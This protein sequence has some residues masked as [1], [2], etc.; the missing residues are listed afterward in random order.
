MSA[1]SCSSVRPSTAVL[2]LLHEVCAWLPPLLLLL[3]LLLLPTLLLLLLPTLLL[4]LPPLLPVPPTPASP[5]PPSSRFAIMAILRARRTEIASSAPSMK[6]SSSVRIRAST[7]LLLSSCCRRL[8]VGKVAETG[9]IAS[10]PG[11]TA[12]MV[13]A[14]SSAS[15]C[16]RCTP[17]FALRLRAACAK[18]SRTMIYF[19]TLDARFGLAPDGYCIFNENMQRNLVGFSRPTSRFSPTSRVALPMTSTTARALTVAR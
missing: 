13:V 19:W 3:L 6:D 4:L 15:P 12:A 9:G 5:P 10:R 16:A 2:D 11:S 8:F 1:R 14:S 18:S 17:V 7:A